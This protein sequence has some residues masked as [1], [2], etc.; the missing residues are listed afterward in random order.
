MDA[1]RRAEHGAHCPPL[2][3]EAPVAMPE[4]SLSA[5]R[6]SPERPPTSPPRIALR[7][8]GLLASTAVLT[9][10]AAYQMYLAL[11]VGGLTVLEMAVLALYVVLFAWIAFSFSTAFAGFLALLLGRARPLGIDTDAP[12]PALSTRTAL[13][14]PTYNEDPAR[15]MA[16]IEAMHDSLGDL[17]VLPRFD[18][19]ILSDTSD[20]DIWIAEEAQ[21]LRLRERTG[22]HTQIFYRHRSKNEG[23]KSGN[24][25]EWVRRFGGGYQQMIVLD[26]DSLMSGDAIVRLVAAMEHHPRVGL[27]QTLPTV[28]NA[29]TLFARLQQFAGRVYGPLV[30]HGLAWWFGTEGNY[31]G[32]NAVIRVAAFAGSAGLPNLRGRKPFG[33]T[34]LSHDF[35]E[36]A[37]MR[38]AG[39]A[40]H[41]APGLA[42]TF[43]EGPPSLTDHA[44]RDRRWCQGNLQHLA[45][46][47]GR[48]LHWVSR[49][50][51]VIGIAS[52]LTAPLWLLF[53]IVGLLISLQAYF[54]RP[55]Y[56]TPGFA[57]FPQWPAQ[58][59]VRAA[60]VFAGTFG[61]LLAPKLLALLA[62]T[63]Q[64]G[65]RRGA[66]GSARACLGMLIE[67]LIS[68]LIAPITMSVQSRAVAQI[69]RGQDAGWSVQR[70]DD[71]SLPLREIVRGYRTQT[72]LG[73]T[74]AGAAYA[75]SLPLL[76]WMSPVI[77]GLVLAIPLAAL[78]ARPD[79]LLR[80][81]GLLAIPEERNPPQIVAHA[82]RLVADFASGPNAGG[83][84][85]LLFEDDALFDLHRAALGER[86]RLRGEIDVDL[87]VGLAKLEEAL[88]I[89]E[90]QEVLSPREKMALLSS[91]RGFEAL[92]ERAK[93]IGTHRMAGS[94]AL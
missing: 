80:P 23:R 1:L 12:L 89:G 63:A 42:G 87:V 72:V 93:A 16:R 67:T 48:G 31:W 51:L 71:G 36:A 8:T 58:D 62:L 68:G 41:M 52:Y 57:L 5:G 26:A 70:R 49:L 56:F 10:G 40:V 85:A 7:R 64:P 45:V 3:P 24:I 84:L 29:K 74:L 27:I 21:F 69:L 13:L 61:L 47:P 6:R 32:H 65:A 44:V 94:R 14:A 37:L 9:G 78:T 77:C 46:L 25:A 2:P 82:N 73:V 66:G 34:I 18:V 17:G 15:L 55:E 83:A 75:I 33:G 19:F 28:I 11:A 50:H 76:L 38:R 43:E 35:V 54:I 86:G 20:P 59:P 53:L 79:R 91:R 22:G 30:G 39:W 88:S 92:T 4:Q 90:V 60:W 81:L